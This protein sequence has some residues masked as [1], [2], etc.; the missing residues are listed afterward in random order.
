MT[1]N[2]STSSR[3]KW[4]FILLGILAIGACAIL[5]VF[6]L[7]AS[8]LGDLAGIT[9]CDNF[10]TRYGFLQVN[11]PTS[12]RIL[13]ET[14]AE[15]FN[16]TYSII[17]TM[18]AEDLTDLQQHEP[19]TKVDEWQT[20]FSDSYWSEESIKEWQDSLKDYGSPLE[21]MLYGQYGDGVLL[22]HVL[23]DTSDT[24]Q[25]LVRYSASYVD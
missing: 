13:E 7:V 16:P 5:I 8:R 21:S 6:S 24:K 10:S 12:A 1:T 25:Y 22:L 4:I 11:L 20:N 15:G 2:T 18:D 9:D 17:F 19:I 23:M 14:C 3:Q